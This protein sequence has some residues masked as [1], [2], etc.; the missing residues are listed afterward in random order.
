MTRY[1][2]VTAADLKILER[3]TA[4]RDAREPRVAEAR[5]DG[6]A[7]SLVLLFKHGVT[8]IIPVAVFDALASATEAQLADVRPEENGAA[9]FWDS[10]DA[11]MST[12]ALLQIALEMRSLNG[13]AP[14]A[15]S[16]RSPAKAA[17]SRANS[18][19]GGRPRKKDLATAQAS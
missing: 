16:V 8:T 6:A 11:Q 18:A 13:V 10:L 5:Y 15:G 3:E 17:S 19:G 12:T 7:R 9:V 4:A 14:Q 1:T 2:P